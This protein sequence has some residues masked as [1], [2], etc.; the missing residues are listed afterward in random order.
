MKNVIVIKEFNGIFGMNVCCTKDVTDEEI[1][2][3]CNEKNPAGTT[4]GW[5]RVIRKAENEWEEKG[6]PCQC[7]DNPNRIHY[8]VVC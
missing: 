7:A 5:C 6:S 4:N 8:S 3:V 1:L 2:K